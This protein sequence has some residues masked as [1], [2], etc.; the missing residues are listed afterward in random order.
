MNSMERIRAMVDGKPVDRPGVAA[1]YHMPLREPCAKDS[2]YGIINSVK[3]MHWDLCKIQYHGYYFDAAMG[4]EYEPSLVAT[5]LVGPVTKFAV[6]H[7][8]MFRELKAPGLDNE[9]LA[10]QIEITKMIVD[11]LGGKVP[12]LATIFSPISVARGIT[13]GANHPQY[14]LKAI[15]YNPED[16]H[17]GLQTITEATLRFQEELLKI[18]IDG[19]FFAEAFAS[20]DDMDRK[21]HEEFS[22]KYDLE[23]LNACKDR[24]WFN[25]LHVHGYKNLR[26]NEYEE[27]NYPVQAYNWED[28]VSDPTHKPISLADVRKM[29]DKIL[30]GGLEFW[31]DFNSPTNNREEV[32]AVIKRR[33]IEAMES[34]GPNENRF[35]FTPGCSVKMHVPEYRMELMYEVMKEVTGVE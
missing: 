32:K 1:W 7:P 6:Y 11:E 22:T 18:G 31:H 12:I 25:M 21:T 30:M 23:I 5:S 15:E 27:L 19:I 2:A 33:L 35:I 3:A 28:C 29:T 26:F 9:Y 24:T 16:V 4:N 10:R 34:L 14:L 17:A 20:T 8:K 13:G